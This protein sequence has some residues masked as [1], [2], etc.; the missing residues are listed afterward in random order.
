M[1]DK[2]PL[3][4]L[5]AGGTSRDIA[6]LLRPGSGAG[7]DGPPWACVGFLDDAPALAGTTV[8]GLPVLGRLDDA[9]RYPEAWF[10]N[11]LAS[12]RSGPRLRTILGNTGIPRSRVATILHPAS[13]VVGDAT[14]GV[15][16]IV[17]PRTVVLS[18]AQVGA[19]VTILANST[20][21]HDA[22]IEDFS[23]IGSG[24]QLSGRVR[25]G[26][27]CYI[28]SGAMLKEGISVGDDS[29]IGMGA[30]VIRNI[31]AGSVAVGNPAHII[32]ER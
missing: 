25:V 18:G 27:N 6:A 28:G 17:Y 1:A 15:G 26:M 19:F 21:N 9:E 20:V 16:T 2:R 23:T 11:G 30:V 3:I 4:L 5:G 24:A 7:W 31:P 32:R 10:A 29:I 22:E 14:I 12:V 8:A 13:L